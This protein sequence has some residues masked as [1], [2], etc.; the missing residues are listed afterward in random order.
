M[1]FFKY[2]KFIEP[3]RNTREICTTKQSSKGVCLIPKDSGDLKL[4]NSRLYMKVNTASCFLFL[5]IYLIS[6]NHTKLK[7][8]K[9]DY[10]RFAI[11][12]I[13][14]FSREFQKLYSNCKDNI[15]KMNNGM[16]QIR[17]ILLCGAEQKQKNGVKMRL[18]LSLSTQLHDRNFIFYFILFLPEER[19]GFGKIFEFRFSIDLYVLGGLKHN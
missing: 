11:F 12:L 5:R 7:Q 4:L 6:L 19:I 13:I 1:L 18:T 17:F 14:K 2:Y 15:C 9:S 10:K 8:M 3:L 16:I